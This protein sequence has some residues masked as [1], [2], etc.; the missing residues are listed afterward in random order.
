MTMALGAPL[1][2]SFKALFMDRDTEDANALDAEAV[3][4]V[5][6]ALRLATV[7][8]VTRLQVAEGK[9]GL[10]KGIE[11]GLREVAY[12]GPYNAAGS[13]VVSVPSIGAVRPASVTSDKGQGQRDDRVQLSIDPTKKG[14][15]R[16]RPCVLALR[17]RGNG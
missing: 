1:R 5:T 6:L 10:V 7:V 11:V 14:K 8:R 12:K 13:G 2:V 15:D 17:P 16:P 3:K 4:V 9:G